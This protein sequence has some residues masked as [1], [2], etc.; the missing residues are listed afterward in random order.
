[1]RSSSAGACARAPVLMAAS[2]SAVAVVIRFMEFSSGLKASA[3]VTKGSNARPSANAARSTNGKA[4]N[5]INQRSQ[6]SLNW[7][8]SLSQKL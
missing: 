6:A 4:R 2:S 5:V 1:M 7:H 3:S 8:R